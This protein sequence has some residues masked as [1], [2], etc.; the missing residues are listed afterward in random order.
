LDNSM[1]DVQW[2]K[3]KDLIS[4]DY[5]PFFGGRPERNAPIS[6]QEIVDLKIDLW[7]TPSVNS[8][9]NKINGR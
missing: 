3:L 2:F 9:L 1:K 6:S 4:P 5:I 8:F 7:T